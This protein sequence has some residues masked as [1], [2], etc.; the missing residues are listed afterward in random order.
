MAEVHNGFY[1]NF[2]K[3]DHFTVEL[4]NTV[5]EI[6]LNCPK[7]LNSMNLVFFTELN[8]IF[9]VIEQTE[10]DI[11][12]VVISFEG[13]HFSSGLNSFLISERCSSRYDVLASR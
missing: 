8:E 9:K 10:E 11:R 13:A 1:N 4:K 5:L 12:V 7:K 2:R 6:R 3:Y